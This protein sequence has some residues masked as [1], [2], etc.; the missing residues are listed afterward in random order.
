MQCMCDVI[1]HSDT[2]PYMVTA[3]CPLSVS[4][5]SAVDVVSILFF[6][7]F[8]VRCITLLCLH[9]NL[10]YKSMYM[11]MHSILITCFSYSSLSDRSFSDIMQYPVM[12]WV[13]ADYTST[14][15]GMYVHVHVY[16]YIHACTVILLLVHVYL[17]I[18]F[19]AVFSVES[20][21]FATG[22]LL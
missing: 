10:M 19:Q 5:S 7:G 15:L 20:L 13:L 1:I 16:M 14:A 11:Y 2:I 12:P 4:I 21:P 22:L 8:H 3:Y 9:T 6:V 17:D 18:F